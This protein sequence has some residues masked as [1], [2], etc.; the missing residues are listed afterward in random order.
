MKYWKKGGNQNEG[1]DRREGNH[2]KKL[3]SL[4]IVIVEIICTLINQMGLGWIFR[5]KMINCHLRINLCRQAKKG[6]SG[7]K[8]CCGMNF[9]DE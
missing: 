6:E 7:Q 8:T 4:Q 9:N 1:G 5:T 3:G 2:T